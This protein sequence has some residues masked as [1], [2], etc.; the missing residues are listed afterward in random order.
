M[1]EITDDILN[2][3]IDGELSSSEVKEID[4]ILNQS[5]EAKRR[6]I[7]LQV[8]H[9]E[10]KKFPV[11]E[12]SIEFTSRLM[13]KIAKKPERKGQ[14]YFIF[15]VSS[16]FVLISLAIIGYLTSYI[17]SL[18]NAA[19]ENNNN[20]GTLIS[21]TESLIHVIRAIFSNGNVSVI[22]VIFS[23]GIFV[24]AYFFFDSHRQAKAKLNKL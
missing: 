12:T 3:Y 2:K 4:E 14:K 5:E 7:A 6:L 17:L 9:N 18:N 21:Y 13:K 11:Y 22:G 1:I 20:V 16:F 24:S 15:S 19:P 23:F 8:V 10:L